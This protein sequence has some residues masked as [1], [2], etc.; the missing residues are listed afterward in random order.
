MG[1]SLK[2]QM[3]EANRLGV[4]QVVIIGEEELEKNI[5]SVKNMITCDQ[6]QIPFTDIVHYFN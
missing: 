4:K 5:G 3:R 2:A 6:I 1:R